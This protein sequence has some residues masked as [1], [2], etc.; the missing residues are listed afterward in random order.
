METNVEYVL[1]GAGAV[2]AI[3]VPFMI[4]LVLITTFRKVLHTALS[5]G[6]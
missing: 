4:P 3:C 2:A 5:N 6:K 1:E